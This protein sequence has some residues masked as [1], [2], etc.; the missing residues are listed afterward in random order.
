MGPAVV[1]NILEERA[2]ST[3]YRHTMFI[4]DR[5]TNYKTAWCLNPENHNFN[6]QYWGKFKSHKSHR[7]RFCGKGSDFL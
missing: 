1:T 4:Q 3:F 2:A 6:P 7:A 5:V